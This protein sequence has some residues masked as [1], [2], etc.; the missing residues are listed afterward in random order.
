[1]GDQWVIIE[2]CT[3]ADGARA[4]KELAVWPVEAIPA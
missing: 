2:Q 4:D 3:E 1:M